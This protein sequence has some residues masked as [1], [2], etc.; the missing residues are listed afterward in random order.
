MSPW[1]IKPFKGPERKELKPN[2]PVLLQSNTWVQYRNT[3]TP[4][5][6][7]VAG[8]Y[9]PIYILILFLCWPNKGRSLLDQVSLPPPHHLNCSRDPCVRQPGLAAR[10]PSMLLQQSYYLH[11]HGLEEVRSVKRTQPKQKEMEE[12][13]ERA[14]TQ[15]IF[16]AGENNIIQ[17]HWFKNWIVIYCSRSTL[18]FYTYFINDTGF[19]TCSGF[20]FFALFFFKEGLFSMLPPSSQTHTKESATGL[21][22]LFSF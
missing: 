1:Q 3:E 9:L 11:H 20:I 6:F 18:L 21:C 17:E 14:A 12:T 4:H 16:S 13:Q 7:W 8:H 5:L 15:G 2:T 22:S 19:Y 10:S